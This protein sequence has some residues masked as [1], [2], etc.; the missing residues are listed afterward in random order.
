MSS[1]IFSPGLAAWKAKVLEKNALRVFF[2]RYFPLDLRNWTLLCNCRDLKI[3]TCY[4]RHPGTI[5]RFPLL[6]EL[7]NV[8]GKHVIAAFVNPDA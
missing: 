4:A 5:I 7:L 8:E 6:S 3:H 2:P 1:T